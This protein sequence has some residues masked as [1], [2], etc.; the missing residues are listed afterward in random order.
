MRV[1]GLETL[2]LDAFPNLC[3]VRVHTDAGLVG[4][5]ET[6]F[7]ARA[8]EAYLHESVA[9][10]L[11]GQDPLRRDAHARALYGYLGYRSTGVEMR[12]NSAV[13]LA[14]WDLFGKATG[15]PVYQLLGGASRE[16]IRTYNTCAGYRYVRGR[17]VQAV[18]N[19]GLPAGAAAGPY[20][21]LDAFLRRPG[22]LARDLLA[23]GITGMKI[24]PFDPYA[25]ASRGTHISAADLDRALEPFRQ[26]RA[27]VGSAMDVMVEF[28]SLWTL[29]AALRI[30]RALE[31]FAPYWFEDPLKA[32]NLDAL[33][34]FAAATHVPTVASETLA[35]R[36]SFREV[37]ERGAARIV[38]LDLSW[39][40]GLTEAKQVAA[41]AEAY[42]LPV[43]PHDCTGPVVLVAST[44]LAINAPNALVQE[45]V[46]AYYAGW[47]RELVTHLPTI[48]DGMIAPPPGPGLGT[49]L[50]PGLE[51][52]PDA[53]ARM[54]GS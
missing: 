48:A 52:R 2:R 5:G 1:T 34:T 46:R 43:A 3:F 16:R 7:G 28:H 27:A 20:E 35:T 45:S 17:P 54:S 9:P 33:A 32:D 37:L 25:E 10:Y 12:G 15:Q 6:F 18:D 47:Y 23:Q 13:D 39:C 4:L 21:D 50:L 41:M 26:I 49:E 53:H 42:Q 29:P 8:V 31:P 30:A 19:W 24:W 40:G 51:A 22:E 11:L 44:H 14:L 38:M 36:W